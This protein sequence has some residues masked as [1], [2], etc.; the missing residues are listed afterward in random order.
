[1]WN[2]QFCNGQGVLKSYFDILS[3]VF[4]SLIFFPGRKQAQ[5]AVAQAGTT[6][7]QTTTTVAS[8]QQTLEA[9]WAAYYAAQ[10]AL[11][12]VFF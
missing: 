6:S 4:D 1:M 3:E 2:V 7:S 11:Q 12:Q 5:E 9:Q 10:S 8:P